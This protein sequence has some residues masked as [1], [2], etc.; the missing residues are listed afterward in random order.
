MAVAGRGAGSLSRKGASVVS[1]VVVDG[2]DICL[3]GLYPGC[4]R[5]ESDSLEVLS[6]VFY[7]RVIRLVA[8]TADEK[9][10]ITNELH[11]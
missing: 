7:S 8:G 9:T 11:R 10:Y 2:F 4:Q 1:T 5:T 6:F 3:T